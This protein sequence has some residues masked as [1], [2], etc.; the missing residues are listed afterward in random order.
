MADDDQEQQDAP[1]EGEAKGS[2]K[3]LI[4]FVILVLVLILVSIGGTLAVVKLLA[5]DA[6]PEVQ[7][8]DD[9][10]PI[11]AVVEEE[12]PKSPAIYFP[13]KPPLIVNYQAR[14]RQRFLQAE[15]SLMAREDDVIEAIE[16][17]MPMIRNSLILLFS[18]QIYE[19]L[20]T[21]EGRELLRQDAL[22][23]LQAIMEQELGKPGIEKL[24]F[25]NFVM[26]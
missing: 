6:E 7:L 17:H 9:G 19:E 11:E 26:Q 3:K 21:D 25:T 14:G 24:L 5:P 10:N 1:E 16:L 15:I 20:Q 8:D 13:L 2:K 23:E 18:G 22:L 12:V 4:L